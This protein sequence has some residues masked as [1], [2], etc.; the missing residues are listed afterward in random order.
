[1]ALTATVYTVD[2]QLSDVDRGVYESFSLKVAQQPSETD[3]FMVARVLA[4]CLEY[5]EGIAFSKG[6][7]E[8]D[9]PAIAVRDLTGTM[10]TWI[11]VGM[12]A[13]ERLHKASK[14]ARRVIVYT[15][16]DAARLAEQLRGERI[17]RAKDIEIVALDRS[18]IASIVER[19]DRRMRLDV[20]VTEGHLY[21]T[22]R[23]E[24]FDAPLE[25]LTIG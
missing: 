20:S 10:L 25:R 2:V 3:E 18:L 11:D 13:A 7:A 14:L 23:D 17:H 9:E 4:Y 24:T 8:P 5:H 16:K 12:P 6:L 22:I 15:H 1:M 19:L 21:V